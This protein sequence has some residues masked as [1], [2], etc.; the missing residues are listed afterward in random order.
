MPPFQISLAHAGESIIKLVDAD[1]GG[2]EW[3]LRQLE[4]P[5]FIENIVKRDRLLLPLAG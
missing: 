5:G 2:I 3:I 1:R 4:G